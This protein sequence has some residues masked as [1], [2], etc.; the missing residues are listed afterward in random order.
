MS[1]TDFEIRQSKIIENR[2]AIQQEAARWKGSSFQKKSTIQVLKELVDEHEGEYL[3]HFSDVKEK[4]GIYPR[5]NFNTPAGVY[6]YVLTDKI[7]NQ[8]VNDNIPFAGQRKYIYA[9]TIKPDANVI[10][11]NEYSDT[12]QIS[13]KDYQDALK[14]LKEFLSKTIKS[15]S[16]EEFH[17]A[18]ASM[19]TAA[20]NSKA[21]THFGRL[22]NITR[23]LSIRYVSPDSKPTSTWNLLLR[24][25]GIDAVLDYGAGLIHE[26]EPIQGVVLKTNNMHDVRFL[27]N[28]N[29]SFD[30]NQ[31]DYDNLHPKQ[32]QHYLKD[33][34]KKEKAKTYIGINLTDFS[35]ESI[36]SFSTV[37][38]NFYEF[39][40]ECI[41][42]AYDKAFSKVD[43]NFMDP[44]VNDYFYIKHF[45]LPLSNYDGPVWSNAQEDYGINGVYSNQMDKIAIGS[46]FTKEGKEAIVKI[47]KDNIDNPHLV[48]EAKKIF[49]SNS[50]ILEL[51][52]NDQRKK[53]TSNLINTIASLI[54]QVDD[55][56]SLERLRQHKKVKNS[57]DMLM[58]L[59]S[60]IE[61]NI[62]QDLIQKIYSL[63]KTLRLETIVQNKTEEQTRFFSVFLTNDNVPDDLVK[64]ILNKFSST[65][66]LS[67]LELILKGKNLDSISDNRAK[68]II[69]HFVVNIITEDSSF[70]DIPASLSHSRYDLH[71]QVVNYVR[72]YGSLPE[73]S[74]EVLT[75]INKKPHA[76]LATLAFNDRGKYVNKYLK[77]DGNWWYKKLMAIGG[78][79]YK[80][81]FFYTDPEWGSIA[82]RFYR[83]DILSQDQ[84]ANF[85]SHENFDE[86]EEA[87]ILR[88]FFTYLRDS[89]KPIDKIIKN[90]NLFSK[91]GQIVLERLDT[92]QIPN[93]KMEYMEQAILLEL[94]DKEIHELSDRIMKI[95]RPYIDKHSPSLEFIKKIHDLIDVNLIHFR[96]PNNNNRRLFSLLYGKKE[97]LSLKLGEHY[98]NKY[99][100]D[101]ESISNEDKEYI[102]QEAGIDLIKDKI[103][104]L[105]DKYSNSSGYS[106]L[107]KI[108][109]QYENFE[110]DTQRTRE[111]IAQLFIDEFIK[112]NDLSIVP[113]N[114]DKLLSIAVSIYKS[115]KETINEKDS[116]KFNNKIIDAFGYSLKKT[117]EKFKRDVEKGDFT[118]MQTADEV[119]RKSNPIA[120]SIDSFFS[121]Y[122][123]DF[124][125]TPENVAKL[126][127]TLNKPFMQKA[128]QL[129][130][131]ADGNRIS[132]IFK[133]RVMSRLVALSSHFILTKTY[134]ADY[135]QE[136]IIKRFKKAYKLLFSD[137]IVKEFQ[138]NTDKKFIQMNFTSDFIVNFKKRLRMLFDNITNTNFDNEKQEEINSSIHEIF[139][140]MEEDSTNGTINDKMVKNL[141]KK[142]LLTF[143]QTIRSKINGYSE[144][145]IF[146]SKKY[147]NSIYGENGFKKYLDD[148]LS[149]KVWIFNEASK[150]AEEA[151]SYNSHH[152]KFS[153]FG[154]QIKTIFKMAYSLVQENKE[155]DF[156]D[157]FKKGTKLETSSFQSIL[158]E[159]FIENELE[160]VESL[161]GRKL[162]KKIY[163]DFKKEGKANPDFLKKSFGGSTYEHAGYLEIVL[164]KFEKFFG[165][166]NDN[167]N[168]LKKRF[169]KFKDV[170]H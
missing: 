17:K 97:N 44:E 19:E 116:E 130:V 53:S 124:K 71:N 143:I 169:A 128:D 170:I 108:I 152:F 133:I 29:S 89:T 49:Q 38:D 37:A 113:S 85:L 87:M 142:V 93:D 151:L 36:K 163:E 91:K 47:F 90:I 45:L 55:H 56:Y 119:S 111:E 92:E 145:K 42:L 165:G 13:D 78:S 159:L 65:K 7:Y 41:S 2:I 39:W 134:L 12:N 64:E 63:Y 157:F 83:N 48:G 74:R 106:G 126:L 79:D 96:A 70:F 109:K 148:D 22:W 95:L 50:K 131:N 34:I 102:I 51:M 136:Q 11:I 117:I 25:L 84:V 33:P 20:Q 123:N 120:G 86:D 27:K 3:I 153:N 164:E 138:K 58:L 88:R 57:F 139:K 8:V 141:I 35:L 156:S 103:E 118:P 161:L 75:Q 146:E 30:N 99:F 158:L 132:E 154:E 137:D 107:E 59:F 80:D 98:Y 54:N 101:E 43:W 104:K 15:K 140:M 6:G 115:N 127:N 100:S 10:K 73:K 60:K 162:L 1:Y 121:K 67:D 166:K 144:E 147:F 23:I 4:L 114:S 40:N 52:E 32:I 68:I 122:D 94:E 135:E 14:K 28:P 9:F 112:K 62:D 105:L 76:L 129:F 66:N 46:N 24:Y 18:V 81:V 82:P 160:K 110:K 72:K 168:E 26:S 61:G 21:K 16:N 155:V 167:M 150:N 77:V 69:N 31:I 149:S 5:T 125:F